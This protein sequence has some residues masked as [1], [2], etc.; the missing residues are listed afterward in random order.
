ME[1][2]VERKTPQGRT[3]YC[4][5]ITQETTWDYD[6]IDENTGQLKVNEE[7]DEEG[8]DDEDLMI[9]HP[10]KHIPTQDIPSIPTENDENELTSWGHIGNDIARAIHDLLNALPHRTHLAKRIQVVVETV[11]LML[12]SSRSLEKDSLTD[13]VFR[14]PRRSVMACL[15]KL[16]LSTKLETDNSIQKM[17]KDAKDVLAAVRN[18]VTLCQQRKVM[19]NQM[20][21]KFIVQD[22]EMIEAGGLK[23]H[24]LNADLVISLQTHTNQIYTSTEELS[25]CLADILFDPGSG[26]RIVHL[27]KGFSGY[28]SQYILLL[29]DINMSDASSIFSKYKVSRQ[30][31]YT[32]IGRLFSAIQNLTMHDRGSI[33]KIPPSSSIHAVEQAILGV[34]N[35]VED[36]EQHIMHMVEERMQSLSKGGGEALTVLND[37]TFH[38][39]EEMDDEEEME[40]EEEKKNGD[41]QENK[42]EPNKRSNSSNDS[43]DKKSKKL[44]MLQTR[45]KSVA[46][47]A[48]SSRIRRARESMYTTTAT[49]F[50][51]LHSRHPSMDKNADSGIVLEYD[52]DTI[53]FTADNNVKGGTLS[54]LVERL[55]AHDVLD[56]SFIAT[57]LLTYRSFCTTKEFITL[58]ET[59]YN[60]KPPKGVTPDELEVWTE[61]KQKLIRLSIMKNWLENYYIDEDFPLLARFEQFTNGII[62][63]TFEF[64]ANQ[65]DRLIKKRIESSGSIKKIVPNKFSGPEP[66]YPKNITNIQQLHEIEPLEMARQL[67]IMDFKLYSSIRPIELLGKAWSDHD[68]NGIAKN[69]KASIHYCNRLTSWVTDSILAHDEAKRRAAVIKFWVH[70]AD[71][72]RNHNNY[73]TCMAILSAFDNSA[74]GRLKKTWMMTNKNTLQILS[75]IRKLMGANRNFTEYREIIHSVNPPCIPFLGI[76]LQDLTFIEDGNPDC[77]RK[78]KN[79][80]NFAKRNKAAEVIRELKQFQSF[81]F[82]FRSIQ[83]LQDF[84]QMHLD[85]DHDVEK[86]YEKS[87]FLEPRNVESS[88][89]TV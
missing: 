23:K 85:T 42:A 58:L 46:D 59:R 49:E 52:P 37:P 81:Q 24:P 82:N 26:D 47:R 89:N 33:K 73:N 32:A 22:D 41:E 86:L 39:P 50:T 35:A 56:T 31:L 63:D 72:C 25:I 75:Q 12:Y 55:T 84:I 61:R 21:L 53:E 70:V 71:Y 1:K 48:A 9:P 40:E 67:S 74:I 62:R 66:I 15:S 60:V 14:E 80:I 13:P 69:I 34:E 18:F 3:Y 78:T 28:I 19:V 88:N 51:S 17:T 2:W 77:L 7:H 38:E 68:V 29:D 43:H 6:E 11:R 8:N 4:N 5:L 57:F 30:G 54:A 65:L 44:E 16:I 10:Q 36:I 20:S 87:L 83:E 64:A 27:F 76:Y 45:R 79:L